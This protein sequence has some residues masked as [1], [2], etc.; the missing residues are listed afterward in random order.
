MDEAFKGTVVNRA[1]PSLS[2]VSLEIT[3]TF[4]FRVKNIWKY[5]E[6]SEIL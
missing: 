2:A 5:A 1:L 6:L 3:L 4:P